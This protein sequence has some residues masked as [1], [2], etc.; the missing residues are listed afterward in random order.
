MKKEYRIK[1][2]SEIDAIFKKKQTK[3]DGYFSI[4]TAR[5]DYSQHFRF[6]ISIGKKYGNAVFR[7][8]IK[9]QIRMIVQANHQLIIKQA[10]FVVVVKPK[11]NTLTFKEIEQ[12]METLLRKSKLLENTHA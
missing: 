2:Y 5:D 7:N 10:L 8:K 11:A 6:A 4:Y 12:S 1:K 9:R 3:S